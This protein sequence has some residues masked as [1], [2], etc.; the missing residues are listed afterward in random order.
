MKLMKQR[1]IRSDKTRTLDVPSQ[2]NTLG[3]S[4]PA[5]GGHWS[6]SEEL[7]A[8]EAKATML[9]FEVF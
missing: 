8:T 5:V 2:Y 3:R 9:S 4:G 6:H 7:W 1:K